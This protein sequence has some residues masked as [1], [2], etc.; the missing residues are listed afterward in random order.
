[1]SQ[2]ASCDN[3]FNLQLFYD[4]I[5]ATFEKNPQDPWVV[6]SLEWWNELVLSFLSLMYLILCRQVPGL[7]SRVSKH[8]KR[9]G[10]DVQN[11]T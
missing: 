5:V 10:P 8:K 4:N 11:R 2:W 9:T 7:R 1:M 6:E 3:L